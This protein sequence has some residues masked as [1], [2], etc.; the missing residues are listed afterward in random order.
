M[1]IA[2]TIKK[3]PTT[4]VWFGKPVVKLMQINN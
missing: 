3:I 2:N 1:L 4:N